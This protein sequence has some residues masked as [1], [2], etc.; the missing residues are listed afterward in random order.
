MILYTIETSLTSHRALD[1]LTPLWIF[2][3]DDCARTL[4]QWALIRTQKHFAVFVIKN[5]ANYPGCCRYDAGHIWE[6]T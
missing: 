2:V 4:Q 6:N 1:H 3:L 5:G